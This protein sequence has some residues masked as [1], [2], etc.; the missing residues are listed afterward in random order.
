M[1]NIGGCQ[2]GFATRLLCAAASSAAAVLLLC[3]FASVPL[4]T[5]LCAVLCLLL[6]QLVCN[7]FGV[8]DSLIA[9]FGDRRIWVLRSQSAEI[10][11]GLGADLRG[12]LGMLQQRLR[13]S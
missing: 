2:E 13:W 7:I 6:L 1:C 4:L 12:G 8:R 9:L 11:V 3:A 5:M 10:Q